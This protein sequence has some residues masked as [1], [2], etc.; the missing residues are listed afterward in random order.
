MARNCCVGPKRNARVLDQ[1]CC[2]RRHAS[3]AAGRAAACGPAEP[4][5]AAIAAAEPI[6]GVGQLLVAGHDHLGLQ[7]R[8]SGSPSRPGVG[9][10][11]AAIPVRATDSQHHAG[12]HGDQRGTDQRPLR[13]VA[14]DPAVHGQPAVR[15]HSDA[16]KASSCLA[17]HCRQA[18]VGLLGGS[19]P[20]RRATG[21]PPR[22]CGP[23]R[24]GGTGCGR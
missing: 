24:R 12:Q 19:R 17:F 18:G 13:G 15:V 23:D 1:A 5:A 11:G 7:S 9:R 14:S 8:C 20:R 2:V 10:T 4:Q 6:G 3:W 16:T 22:G 21:S